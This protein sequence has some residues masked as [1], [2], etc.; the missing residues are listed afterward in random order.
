VREKQS[1]LVRAGQLD[2]VQELARE[3]SPITRAQHKLLD[4]GVEIIQA[5]NAVEL[6]FLAKEL[7]HC[8]LPHSNPGDMLPLWM[9]TNGNF[10]LA[11]R[12]GIDHKTLKPIGYPYGSIPRLLLFWMNTE[13]VRIKSRRLELGKNLA[14]FMSEIGLD[15]NTGR[16]KRGDAKRLREQMRRLFRATISFEIDNTQDP[17]RQGQGWRDMQVAPEGE[18]WWDPK[19][20][21]QV[22]LWGS[23]IEL[24][25]KFFQAITAAPVPTDLRALRALKQSPLALDLYIWAAHKAYSAA[26]KNKSQFV[27]WIALSRQFGADYKQTRDFKLKAI[28]ALKKIQAVY[29]GLKLQD[30]DGGIV[31]LASSRPAVLPAVR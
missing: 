30:A 8:T 5:P 10:T 11:V 29:P 25:E 21:D 22:N 16:G 2:F 14:N 28:G 27:P 17:R 24:G 20:P 31:V 6:A 7:V 4:A 19:R 18:L 12:P 9:R 23:W 26:V 3:P 1:G 15:S 13:A